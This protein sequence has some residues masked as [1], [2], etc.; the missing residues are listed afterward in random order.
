MS[1]EAHP[2]GAVT[3]RSNDDTLFEAALAPL[4]N[5]HRALI[6]AFPTPPQPEA[7]EKTYVLCIHLT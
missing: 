2:L 3:D 5:T 7:L 1:D 4:P 6:G